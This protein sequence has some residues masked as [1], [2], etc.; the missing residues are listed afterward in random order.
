[1]W[2][3]THC[4]LAGEEYDADRK[5]VLERAHEANVQTIIVIGAGDGL[6]KNVDAIQ[7]A[8]KEDGCFTT[9]GIHPHD[10]SKVD[11]EGSYLRKLKEWAKHPKVVAIGE[12]GLDYHYKHSPP[13]VQRKR[14]LEQIKLAQELNFPIVVH[15]R[16]AWQDTLKVI[17][18]A[19]APT[20]KGVFHCF[21]GSLEEARQALE[22]GFYIS[23]A[24]VPL[25]GHSVGYLDSIDETRIR[26][27]I[28]ECQCSSHS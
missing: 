18:E 3:D 15:S 27:S 10:A 17:N 24:L 8:E 5:E 22:L 4:H 7:L 6:D 11:E 20:K 19:G 16:E 12:I 28:D 26:R 2:T 13:G 23:M 9:I 14:F 1:M 21:G 25:A